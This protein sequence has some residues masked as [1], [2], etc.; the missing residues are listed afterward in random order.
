MELNTWKRLG[1]MGILEVEFELLD[2]DH[3][4]FV[5]NEELMDGSF[6]ELLVQHHV[7][8]AI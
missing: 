2:T 6:G 5:S 3:D 4:G 8:A 7:Q 1:T